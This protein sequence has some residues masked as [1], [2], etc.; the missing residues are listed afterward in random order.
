M[1]PRPKAKPCPKCER[2]IQPEAV[3]CW[4]CGAVFDTTPCPQ[5][6]SPVKNGLIAC[7][8][9]GTDM[10]AA[11]APAA[12]PAPTPPA[13]APVA[14]EPGQETGIQTGP[15]PAPPLPS[16]L[17]QH[18]PNCDAKLPST[19][20]ACLACGEILTLPRRPVIWEDHPPV[21]PHR[22]GT[23]L[24]LAVIALASSS[25]VLG[26]IVAVWRDSI[27]LAAPLF[28]GAS[29]LGPI[30]A[31]IATIDLAAM[32]E[33][34]MDAVGAGNTRIAQVLAIVATFGGAALTL[35]FAIAR[36]SMGRH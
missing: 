9:C 26:P 6:N 11:V 7:W 15:K 24:P 10:P 33:G 31:I 4:F 17:G 28:C 2:P 3:R 27:Y 20:R 21:R 19:G 23:L 34:R 16:L 22:A 32:R 18:C 25:L 29:L 35:L 8:F 30:V 14:R 1:P 13:P 36:I 5:C 12:P